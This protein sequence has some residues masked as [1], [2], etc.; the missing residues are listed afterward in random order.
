M[1]PPLRAAAKY[2]IA[3]R[4]MVDED[5][6]FLAALYASTR[7]EEVA[8]TGWPPETQRAFLAQQ[9]HAQHHH[10]QTYYTGAE[11]L[12]VER[13][14]E[15]IGR[16]YLDEREGKAYVIDLS[17]VPEARGRGIGGAILTDVID[18]AAAAGKGVALHVERN[19]PA[20]GLYRRLGFELVEDN[21]IY[22]LIE[23]PAPP[24]DQ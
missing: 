23:R 12:I 5:L 10:Y 18:E 8:Q 3:Y 21:G 1:P 7:A 14:G 9:H 20:L 15:R 22:L 4:P 13:A 2:G 19:N 11:W 16:L 17:L 24:R 6:P